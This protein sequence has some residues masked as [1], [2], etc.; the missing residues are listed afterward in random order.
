MQ[1][2]SSGRHVLT[3]NC[4]TVAWEVPLSISR[5]VLLLEG[6]AILYGVWG[7]HISLLVFEILILKQLVTPKPDLAEGPSVGTPMATCTTLQLCAF[8]SEASDASVGL[9]CQQKLENW[10][11]GQVQLAGDRQHR[12]APRASCRHWSCYWSWQLT[13][14]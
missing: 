10:R 9:H 6:S 3:T 5:Y 12:A 13:G 8:Q 4:L 1:Q 14:R 7:Q 11:G 2:A